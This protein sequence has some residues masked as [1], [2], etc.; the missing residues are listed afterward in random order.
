[1]PIDEKCR[2]RHVGGDVNGMIPIN[3]NKGMTAMEG[4][5]KELQAGSVSIIE[6]NVEWKKIQSRET[7]NHLLRKTWGGVELCS[8]DV[9][10]KGRYK[11]GGTETVAL[12]NWSHRV[13]GRGRDPTGCGRWSY[14][15]YGIKV[16]RSSPIYRPTKYATTKIIE[17]Q[18]HGYNNTK[19]NMQTRW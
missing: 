1:M 6:T 17:T 11:P 7:T 9:R 18:Q 4:N 16:T 15:T 14:V 3:N 13:V 8:S 2:L 5:L 12:V 10:F 19:H